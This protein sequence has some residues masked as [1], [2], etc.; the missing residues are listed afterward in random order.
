[1][2]KKEKLTQIDHKIKTLQ[3]KK[4]KL[5]DKYNLELITLMKRAGAM[6]LPEDI[7]L[8]ALLEAVEAFKANSPCLKGWQ[9]TG[10]VFFIMDRSARREARE[11]S[12]REEK[13]EKQGTKETEEGEKQKS[14]SFPHNPEP[15][16][17][18]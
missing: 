3:N 1:M 17:Q 9:S 13:Q 11:E 4:K 15:T 8:G 18:N 5:A 16:H 10:R 6:D 12:E 2:A 14:S 7:L